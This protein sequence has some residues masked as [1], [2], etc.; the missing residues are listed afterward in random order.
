MKWLYLRRIRLVN[1]ELNYYF[2]GLS[3]YLRFNSENWM[4]RLSKY[5]YNRN[6]L[7]RAD[8][9]GLKQHFCYGKLKRSIVL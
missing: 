7:Q 6:I 8:F 4:L 2:P 1:I 3:E 9:S 5:Q